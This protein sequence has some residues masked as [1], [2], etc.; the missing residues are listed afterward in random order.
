MSRPK[1]WVE[2]KAHRSKEAAQKHL[3]ALKKNV[4]HTGYPKRKR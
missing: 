4:K 1:G 3:A 2:L